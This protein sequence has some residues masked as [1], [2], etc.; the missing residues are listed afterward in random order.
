ME[1][2]PSTKLID[3]LSELGDAMEGSFFTLMIEGRTV[4]TVVKKC[5]GY[6]S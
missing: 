5:T 2:G 6:E 3:R 1:L 4:Y